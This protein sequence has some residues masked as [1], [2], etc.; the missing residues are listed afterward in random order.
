MLLHPKEK[1]NKI[2]G[3]GEVR[4]RTYEKSNYVDWKLSKNNFQSFMWLFL[5]H[6]EGVTSEDLI[7]S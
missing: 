2:G 5:G 6:I 3:E 7:C 4:L 1:N